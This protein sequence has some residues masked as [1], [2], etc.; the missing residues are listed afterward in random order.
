MKGGGGG[1]RRAVWT[2]NCFRVCGYGRFKLLSIALV[3]PVPSLEI[4][5]EE[6]RDS[7]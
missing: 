2:K 1:Q 3:H 7:I 6:C 5:E 4:L